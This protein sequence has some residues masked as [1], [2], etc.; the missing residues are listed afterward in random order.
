MGAP[1]TDPERLMRRADLPARAMRL[2]ADADA[3]RSMG[4]DRREALWAVRRLPDDEALPLFAAASARELGEEQP[5]ALPEMRLPEHIVADYQTA[6]LSLKGHPMAILRPLFQRE[7]VKSAAE[8]AA[9]RDGAWVRMAGVVLV[10]QRPGKGNAIFIT[11]EDETGITNL[12]LWA[13]MFERYRR[14][15]MGAR[16]ILAEGRVQRSKEGVIHLMAE[17]IHDRT[18]ALRRLSETHEP[19]IELAR[20]DEILRP[21]NPRHRHPRDVRILPKSRDFH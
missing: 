13:R 9:A 14:E 10:R 5:A 16:L 11:L 3:F 18:D 20:A 15:V 4:L 2:L 7:G 8:T 1:F 17:R 6:R 19:A 12:V 21:Q